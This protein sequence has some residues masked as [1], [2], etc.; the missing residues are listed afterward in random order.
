M[1]WVRVVPEDAAEGELQEAYAQVRRSRGRVANVIAISGLLPQVMLR[2]IDFYMALMYGSH[3]LPRPQREMVAV[4]VSRANGCEYC[5]RHHAAALAR[6]ATPE[7]AQR[8]ADGQHAGLPPRDLAMLGYA[9]K[10][11]LTPRLVGPG[12]VDALRRGGLGD[13]EIV[14]VNHIVAY[15]NMMNRIVQ[16]LGVELE[17]DQGAAPEY[18][19]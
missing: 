12:D 19:Y 2:G 5:V 18:K 3:R 7:V 17:P 11:T 15:F 10:L 13:E 14:A 4:E 6:V 1:P 8:V 16:G 9:R